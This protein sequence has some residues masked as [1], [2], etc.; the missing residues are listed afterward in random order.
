MTSLL[1]V[2]ASRWKLSE[3]VLSYC[4]HWMDLSSCQ[5][6]WHQSA[7]KV[8]HFMC[9]RCRTVCR[10]L[11]VTVSVRECVQRQRQK[12]IQI[13]IAPSC[14]VVAFFDSSIVYK[15]SDLLNCTNCPSAKQWFSFGWA[16]GVNDGGVPLQ[17]F[18]MGDFLCH[19]P[20]IFC[21]LCCQS[22]NKQWTEWDLNDA[23]TVTTTIFIQIVQNSV[24][25]WVP[26]RTLMG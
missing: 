12:T 16:I 6:Y 13:V 8:S 10:L 5:E 4:L 3:V 18:N 17:Y 9:P 20:P 7:S 25:A 1:S 23:F 19:I 26:P 15:I 11:N 2:Y 21:R 24:S 22:T 14:A